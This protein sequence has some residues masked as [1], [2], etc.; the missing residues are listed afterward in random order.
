[1]S[2]T[3]YPGPPHADGSCLIAFDGPPGV[4][5]T[6]TVINGPG[7]I[8]AQSAATDASGRAWAIYSPD[9][10]TGTATI[11]VTHGT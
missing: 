10:G 2:M 1:M 5:V 8:D 3:L 4:A 9:G 7:H 6:W 11:E